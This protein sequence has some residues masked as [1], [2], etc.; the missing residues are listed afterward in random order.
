MRL[1]MTLRRAPACVLAGLLAACYTYRPVA[2][3]LTPHSKVSMVL[4]DQ[5]RMATSSQIGPQTARVEG[6]LVTTTDT[7]YVLAVSGVKPISGAW[8]R[9]T[10]ETV[11][12]RRDHVALLY[13]RRLS[14]GRTALFVAVAAAAAVT[15]VI[16]LDLFGFG[17]DPLETIPGGGGDPGDS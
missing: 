7:G 9:W 5:G 14:K 13:E 2:T 6:S 3:G 10:G 17:S 15:T 12:V 16:G 4:S 1:A 11:S 8:V